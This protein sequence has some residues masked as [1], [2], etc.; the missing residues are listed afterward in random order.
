MYPEGSWTDDVRFVALGDD[1]LCAVD[2]GCSEFDATKVARLMTDLGQVYT[3]AN[4]NI[5]DYKYHTFDQVSFLGSTPQK[6]DGKYVGALR[7]ETLYSNLAY[8][9]KDTDVP[10]LIET[11]LDLASV[12]PYDVFKKYLDSVNDVWKIDHNILFSDNYD[13]R[14]EV[15]SKRTA[16]SGASYWKPEGPWKPQG[17][18]EQTSVQ[19]DV[20]RAVDEKKDS[21]VDVSRAVGVVPAS[22]TS[23]VLS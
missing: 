5:P 15:Q 14:R 17:P 20:V 16:D 6:I 1:H 2:D 11:F 3:D 9:T 19:A 21:S 10:V 22:L 4:K 23:P 8:V 13:V 18:G 12:H 7:M